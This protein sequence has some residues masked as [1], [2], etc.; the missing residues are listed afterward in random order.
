H[1]PH[2]VDRLGAVRRRIDDADIQRS[3]RPLDDRADHQA[4]VDH[5]DREAFQVVGGHGCAHPRGLLLN[6]ALPPAASRYAIGRDRGSGRKTMQ[7]QASDQGLRQATE[8]KEVAGVVAAATSDKGI[9]YEGAAGLR[10]AGKSA[11]MTLDTVFW[12][13]SMT[14]AVTSTA[15]LQ[16]VE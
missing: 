3:E 10:E 6:K 1:A 14:K 12:I 8:A 2:Q 9:I 7:T 15:A 5:E 13:A 11:A 16:L 4:V